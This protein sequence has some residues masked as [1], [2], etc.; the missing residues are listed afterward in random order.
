M[1]IRA[2]NTPRYCVVHLDEIE[3]VSCPCGSTKRAFSDDPD[4]VATLHVVEITK[5]SRTHYHK[6]LTELYYVL[7]GEG[8][9]ELD[10]N[11]VNVKPG[12]AIMIKPGCRHRA[13]GDLKILNVPIPAFDAEDE[14]FDP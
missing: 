7:E 13:L 5:D 14:W 2:T 9:I 4:Q 8:Q 6:M 11:L 1:P 12:N 10:G 3:S